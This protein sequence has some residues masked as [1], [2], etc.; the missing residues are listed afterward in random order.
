MLNGIKTNIPSC[1]LRP[2]DVITLREKSKN[3]EVVAASLSVKGKSF[4]WLDW[5]MNSQTGTFIAVPERE[6]I[7]ENINE[8]LIVELYSK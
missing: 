4:P 2:G 7:P 1:S 8:Q 5:N 3:L 6:Q